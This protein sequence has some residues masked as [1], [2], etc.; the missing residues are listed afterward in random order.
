MEEG[1]AAAAAGGG[2][3]ERRRSVVL[4]K[5]VSE[6]RRG[7]RRRL[8]RGAGEI[9]GVGRQDQTRWMG[10]RKLLGGRRGRRI[11]SGL[12]GRRERTGCGLRGQ[13]LLTGGQERTGRAHERN[14]FGHERKSRWGS[15]W[16]HR[17]RSQWRCL[18]AGGRRPP[19]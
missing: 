15:T 12:W 10:V 7:K 19:V 13:L 14:G 9:E 1:I 18:V 6:E 2:A 5:G 4:E 16:P 3:A 17:S 11:G 8:Q